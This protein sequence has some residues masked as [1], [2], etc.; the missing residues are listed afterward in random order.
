VNHV[1]ETDVG[2]GDTVF[3]EVR[4]PPR[5]VMFLWDTSASVNPYLPMIYNSLVAYAADLVPGQD[6][7]NLL[8]FG[9]RAPLLKDW[10]GEPYL[11]QTI[12]NDYPRRESSSDA[13]LTQFVAS[14]LLAPRPG[15]KAIVVL[16]D[17]ATPRFAPV[18]DSFREVRPR[19]FIMKIASDEV[20]AANAET[21][22]DISQDWAMVN[23][24]HYSYLA[25]EGEM[26][27]A[28]DRASTLLRGPAG[29]T[30]SFES[31]YRE[32]PGPGFMLVTAAD[33]TPG[34]AGA[35]ELILD[36][37]GSMW[38]KLDGRFRIDIAKEV[39]SDS[40][41]NHVPPG[42]PTALRVFGHREP[43]TCDTNLEV[44]LQPLDTDAMVAAVNA[45]TPQSLAK[46]P[47]G[48]S[49]A[50]V[51]QDLA[52]AG[53]AAIVV[54]VTDGKETCEGN[55]AAEIQRLRDSAF[56]L[57]LNIV[58]FA[59]DDA[60]LERQFATW[61]EAGG[62][63]YLAANDAAGLSEAMSEALATSYMVYDRSGHAIATGTVGGDPVELEQ[64]QYKVVVESDPR[65]VFDNVR[66]TGA[67]N[68]SIELK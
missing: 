15:T 6:A 9:S 59:I 58:G 26:E 61:A 46:T 36:A 52:T 12:L 60:N 13:E 5:N 1:F 17:A 37:S 53:G 33:G 62:G 40:I 7:A 31:E 18:W 14:N 38:Q 23:G 42:T 28:F 4:E 44:A 56:A 67:S 64:G 22:Q 41:R 49:L 35:V 10:H 51:S 66:I 24:G 65:Q 32:T 20:T 55:P 2:S 29:Y 43:N 63:R 57:S 16:T 11:M 45:I 54:L 48:A 39:L 25:N 3:V 47:L 8:P 50:A 30:L 19:I 27:V 68:T 34:G 21:E